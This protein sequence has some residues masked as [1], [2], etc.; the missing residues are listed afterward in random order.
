MFVWSPEPFTVVVP[1]VRLPEVPKVPDVVPD[2]VP[3]FHCVV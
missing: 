3:E 1:L 2:V